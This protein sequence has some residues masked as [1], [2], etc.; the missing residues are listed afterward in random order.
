MLAILLVSIFVAVIVGLLLFSIPRDCWQTAR[1]N[2]RRGDG[3]LSRIRMQREFSASC[4]YAATVFVPVLLVSLLLLAVLYGIFAYLMPADL[5]VDALEA[6]M[7]GSRH[8]LESVRQLHR[9]EF[10]RRGHT[11]DS[12]RELQRFLWHNWLILAVV[13]TISFV[14]GATFV[15][16]VVSR[17]AGQFV[18]GVTLRRNRYLKQDIPRVL[19]ATAT[20]QPIQGQKRLPSS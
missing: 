19:I 8:E 2:C 15:L 18:R 9:E 13:S 1:R 20:A 17:E 16:R 11:A 6:L 5:M 4:H 3:S 14:I 10:L 12:I 7:S